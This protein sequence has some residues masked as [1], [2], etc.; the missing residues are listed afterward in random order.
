[1]AATTAAPAQNTVAASPVANAATPN[2]ARPAPT[3]AVNLAGAAPSTPYASASLYVGDLAPDVTEALLFEIFNAVGPCASVRV[4]R[5]AAT[6]RSLGY[7]YVNFHRVEDA[8]RALD[9]LNFKPI[10]GRACRIMWCH[11]DPSLRK[12]GLGNIFVNHL[13]K[14]IDHKTLYDTFSRFGNILS[15]KVATNQKGE[16]LGYGFVHFENDESAQNAIQMVDGKKILNSIVSVQTFKSKK[17]RHGTAGQNKGKFTNIFVKNLPGSITKESLEQ[18]FTKA[19]GITSSVIS[20]DKADTS[21]AYGFVNYA[22]PEEA[23]KAVDLLHNTEIDGRKIFV[24]RAQKK[25]ERDKELREKF[26]AAKAERAKKYIGTNLYV[27]NLPDDI[28]DGKL[29]EAFARFGSITSARV[30]RDQN[31]RSKNFGFVCFSAAEEATKAVTEMN[32]KM[33]DNKPLYVAIAQRKEQRRAM[34]ENQFNARTK[35]QAGPMGPHGV[36]NMGFIPGQPGV[37]PMF[38]AGQIPGVG[39]QRQFM[40]PQSLPVMPRWAGPGAPQAPHLMA[41]MPGLPGALRGPNGVPINYQLLP[42]TGPLPGPGVQQQGRPMGNQHQQQRG[43]RQHQHHHQGGRQGASGQVPAGI[44]YNDNVRNAPNR[45]PQQT[46]P[47]AEVPASQPLLGINEPLS[48]KALAAAPEEM[49]KQII[50]ERLFPLVQNQ[51]PNLAGKITGMLLEMDNSELLHLIESQP[52]LTD[53][54]NEALAVLQ[55]HDT[56]DAPADK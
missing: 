47:P 33:L 56:A 37:M 55:Q 36:P 35:P 38:P 48:L 11:R 22:T 18:L 2:G 45:P 46:Q 42:A 51:Q 3:G 27:K 25:E 15:C 14:S 24:G 16:S 41:G 20:I 21:R 52:A 43:N 19:G 40:Y 53:K 49:K 44:R 28:D 32:G 12:S 1:M 34:L 29:R 4:C 26:E 10:R 9:T 6:R 54:I 17:E 30:M 7:A 39:L 23:Q 31:T 8:E 13:D 50:G 5:D